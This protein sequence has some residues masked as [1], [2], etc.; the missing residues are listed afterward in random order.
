MLGNLDED[1]EIELVTFLGEKRSLKKEAERDKE[2]NVIFPPR[3]SEGRALP[4]FYLGELAR[5][6]PYTDLDSLEKIPSKPRN[7]SDFLEYKELHRL[8]TAP[9]RHPEFS[10]M[11]DSDPN[12]F[13][14]RDILRFVDAPPVAWK[15]YTKEP[16]D[17]PECKTCSHARVS[18]ESTNGSQVVCGLNFRLGRFP[19]CRPICYRQKIRI[20]RGEET[21]KSDTELEAFQKEQ[22]AQ[23]SL[24]SDNAKKRETNPSKKP[25]RRIRKRRQIPL[26]S[27]QVET[28]KPKKKEKR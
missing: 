8:T 2:G 6:S 3:D 20:K 16:H 23:M 1:P 24:F 5:A 14:I 12:A 25:I 7:Y 19:A 22:Q 26:Q 17:F 27:G 11:S 15:R 18:D 28:P 10:L 21:L 13:G 4:F 9:Q